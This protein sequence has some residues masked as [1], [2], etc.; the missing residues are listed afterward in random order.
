MIDFVQML[1]HNA[2]YGGS[3]GALHK[4]D[5]HVLE[6]DMA[7]DIILPPNSKAIVFASGKYTLVSECDF[8]WLNQWKWHCGHN[9]YAGRK[10]ERERKDGKRNRGF[11]YLHR[12]IMGAEGGIEVDHIDGN[13][14][15]NCRENL[16]FCNSAQNK[17]NQRPKRGGMSKYK[18]VY[19]QAGKW[20]AQTKSGGI[21]IYLG[22]FSSEIEAAKAYNAEALRIFGSFAN[23]NI[24][25]EG[26]V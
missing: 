12:F 14:L 5:Q 15:N 21:G 16:R 23:L 24:I 19:W 22:R 7:D 20:V 6:Y 9:G 11:I 10:I 25:E 2:V 18:G 4:P 8:D 1:S 3:W 17:H 26:S 13:P